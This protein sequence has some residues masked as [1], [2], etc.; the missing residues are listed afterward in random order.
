MMLLGHNTALCDGY[1][2]RP[3]GRDV[4]VSKGFKYVSLSIN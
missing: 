2:N 1:K 3:V 4:I